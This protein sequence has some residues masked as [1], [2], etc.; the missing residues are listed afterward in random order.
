MSDTSKLSVDFGKQ[1]EPSASGFIDKQKLHLIE[2]DI[3]SFY[4]TGFYGQPYGDK[5]ILSPEE[6]SLLLERSRIS[7]YKDRDLK[8][9]YPL[10]ELIE[11]FSSLD[12]QFWGRYLVYKDLRSRGYVVRS[13]YGEFSPYRRY[14]RGTKPGT[15][16]NLQDNKKSG[17]SDTVIY[18]FLEGNFLEL[19]QLD[20]IVNLAKSNRKKLILG[21]VDRSG[22]VTYYR[23]S[24]FQVPFNE[25]RYEW[26]SDEQRDKPQK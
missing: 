23:A 3:L 19:D 5:L 13:G 26:P 7:I 15:T 16:K 6:A 10:D 14:P 25:E 1:S 4:E 21:V 11:H 2:G 8:N 20:L 12:K 9:F 22:D 18:P 24:E 17:V